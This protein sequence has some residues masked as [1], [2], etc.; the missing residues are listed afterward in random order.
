MIHWITY[1]LVHSHLWDCVLYNTTGEEVGWICRI[2]G[3]NAQREP[4]EINMEAMRG[5]EAR[6]NLK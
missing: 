4:L 1:T 2:C 5:K 6:I 3:M